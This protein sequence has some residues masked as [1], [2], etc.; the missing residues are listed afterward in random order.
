MKCF[1]CNKEMDREDG[2][3]TMK[4]VK[5]DVTIEEHVWTKETKDYNNLQLGKYSNGNGECHVAACYECYID[6]LFG[7]YAE[8]D[9]VHI[10]KDLYQLMTR[11]SE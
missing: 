9:I 8:V 11:G 10:A 6:G 4:G 3:A 7:L 5:V 1:K 2:G